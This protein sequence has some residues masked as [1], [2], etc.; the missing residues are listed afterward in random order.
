MVSKKLC[1]ARPYF[2][3][4]VFVGCVLSHADIFESITARNY[5]NIDFVFTFNLF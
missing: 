3:K 1:L 5:I 4:L 2:L